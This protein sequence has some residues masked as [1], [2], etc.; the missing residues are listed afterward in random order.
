MYSILWVKTH[1]SWL[2]KNINNPN[3]ECADLK[4]QA[5]YRF[6]ADHVSDMVYDQKYNT[7]WTKLRDE[8]KSNIDRS[9][10]MTIPTNKK[11]II[12]CY[13]ARQLMNKVRNPYAIW[14]LPLIYL[15]SKNVY[16]EK[17]KSEWD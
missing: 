13:K 9:L 2:L 14:V 16:S 10:D 5:E 17:I 1:E 3:K 6:I 15:L 11:F 8:V 7:E 4:E 12:E